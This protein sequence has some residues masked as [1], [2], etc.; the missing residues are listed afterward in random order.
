MVQL[1]LKWMQDLLFLT[2]PDEKI[3]RDMTADEFLK[4]LEPYSVPI[5]RP[6]TTVFLLLHDARVRAVIHEA[7][8]HGNQKAFK[9]LAMVLSK[10]IQNSDFDIALVRLIPIPLGKTRRK[11]RGFNQVEEVARRTATETG[12][13]LNTK[14][15]V[16]TRDTKSQVTLPR[17]EREENMHDAFKYS[18]ENEKTTSNPDSSFLYIVLDDVAT[19]G[20]TLQAAIDGLRAGGI[21][22]ILPLALTH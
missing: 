15:L 22:H 12:I 21:T 13:S 2:R 4:L 20:A 8:Y 3:L 9:F 5:T 14:L 17:R 7:K 19:T 1:F 10:Y 18:P 6:E 11:E 16:R